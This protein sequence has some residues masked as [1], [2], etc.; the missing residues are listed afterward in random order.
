M[1]EQECGEDR[2]IPKDKSSRS[3]KRIKIRRALLPPFAHVRRVI[4]WGGWR[5]GDK[6]TRPSLFRLHPQPSKSPW[7]EAQQLVTKE[8][9]GRELHRVFLLCYT[10]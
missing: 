5:R 2:R 7:A 9:Q 10:T 4:Y 3:G 6:D 1:G 8:V